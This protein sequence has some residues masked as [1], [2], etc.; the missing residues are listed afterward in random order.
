M[1]FIIRNYEGRCKSG[2]PYCECKAA[3][4]TRSTWA[5]DDLDFDVADTGFY[6]RKALIDIDA[7][8]LNTASYRSLSLARFVG[9]PIYQFASGSVINDYNA[10]LVMAKKGGLDVALSYNSLDFVHESI[11]L[12]EEFAARTGGV[13]IDC[14]TGVMRAARL[15]EYEFIDDEC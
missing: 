4:R 14:N 10:A 12:L 6:E 9:E 13:R 8:D 5:L 7:D 15:D 3:V 2:D 1:D 11:Y